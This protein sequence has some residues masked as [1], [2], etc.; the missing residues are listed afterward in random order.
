MTTGA[1]HTGN[2]ILAIFNI[3]SRPLT[4]LVS[5]SAFPGAIS[6]IQYVVR[7]HTTGKVSLPN[8]V[9][10]PGSLFTMSLPVRGYEILSAFPLTR[11]SSKKH[12]DVLVS[13]LGLL[14][15]MAGAAAI[16]MNDIQQRENGRVLID[17][18]IKAFGI[19]GE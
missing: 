2:P 12:E 4:E 18:R 5:L 11:L 14:G 3:S 1:S 17:T 13:N 6:D 8:K 7:A 19:L 15:K 9:D 10:G 16:F